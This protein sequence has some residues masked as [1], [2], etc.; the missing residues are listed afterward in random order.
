[1]LNLPEYDTQS[2]A[3][4]FR[5]TPHLGDML[6]RPFCSRWIFDVELIARFQSAHARK[7]LSEVMYEFPLHCWRDIPGSKLKWRDFGV[8]M[9]DLLLIKRRYLS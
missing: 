4:L 9:R 8:A 5:V 3:K 7:D 6:Q 1:M 2:G